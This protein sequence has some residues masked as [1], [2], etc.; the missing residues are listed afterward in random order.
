MTKQRQFGL[1]VRNSSRYGT[2]YVEVHICSKEAGADDYAAPLGVTDSYSERPKHLTDVALDG[3]GIYGFISDMRRD[4]GL[5]SFIGD[6]I[7]FRDVFAIDE[8]KAGAML[9][10]LKRVNRALDKAKA[11][12]PGDRFAALAA[13]LKLDFVVEDRNDDLP[14]NGQ[15][16]RYMTVAEGRNRYRQMIEQARQSETDRLFPKPAASVA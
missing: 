14:R 13:A 8:R 6:N 15:R 3:L 1:L 10:T 2:R 5:C 9:K 16:W 7:E 4:D 12:E 11:Y